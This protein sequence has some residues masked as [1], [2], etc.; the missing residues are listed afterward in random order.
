MIIVP[1]DFKVA[2]PMSKVDLPNSDHT[3]APSKAS[4]WPRP[5]NPPEKKHK[6]ARQRLENLRI[7]LHRLTSEALGPGKNRGGAPL[8]GLRWRVGI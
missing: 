6:S 8:E 7:S 1:V 2:R 3:K 5:E 4:N